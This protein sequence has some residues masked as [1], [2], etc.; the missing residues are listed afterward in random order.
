MKSAI[1]LAALMVCASALVLAQGTAKIHGT[2]QDSTGAAVPG[3]EVKAV[4]IDTGLTRA[5]TTGAD[6][7]YVLTPLPVGPYRIE[8]AKE[9]FTKAIQN[10]V[11]LQ[12]GT[13]PAIDI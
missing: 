11:T 10:G 6:G 9:G 12:V 2:I 13:D 5:A 4:Q 1:R 3:A 7:G 8:V